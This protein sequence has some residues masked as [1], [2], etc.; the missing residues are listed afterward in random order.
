M[1]LTKQYQTYPNR[2]KTSQDPRIQVK[3]RTFLQT[4]HQ[5]LAD[6]QY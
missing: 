1:N 3:Q 6:F 5:P 4:M 2:W